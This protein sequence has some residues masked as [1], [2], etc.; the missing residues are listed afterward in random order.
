ME[1]DR[2]N[3][4]SSNSIVIKKR[5]KNRNPLQKKNY[6]RRER[7]FF[8]ILCQLYLASRFYFFHGRRSRYCVTY[9]WPHLLLKKICL[10]CHLYLAQ[11]DLLLHLLSYHG[12]HAYCVTFTWHSYI[13]LPRK[14]TLL[15]CVTYTWPTFICFLSPCYT[16]ATPSTVSPLPA[17]VHAKSRDNIKK[18]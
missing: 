4:L 11:F 12:R 8:L 16:L 7:R 3:A 10:L 1:P 13:I 18:K 9:T 15:N 14:R 5:K 2:K 17:P 6:S